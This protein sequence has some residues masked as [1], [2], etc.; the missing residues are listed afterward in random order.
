MSPATEEAVLE[1]IPSIEP[2]ASEESQS[3]EAAEDQAS[4]DEPSVID[5][6]AESPESVIPDDGSDTIAHDAFAMLPESDSTDSAESSHH[7]SENGQET[8]GEADL[9]SDADAEN[10]STPFNS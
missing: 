10:R 5:F 2:A 1:T 8:S 6:N 9:E 7:A 3:H 4:D